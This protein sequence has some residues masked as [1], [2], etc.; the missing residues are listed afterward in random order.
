M[1]VHAPCR[2]AS[3]AWLQL[4][5]LQRGQNSQLLLQEWLVLLTSVTFEHV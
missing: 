4:V 2:G 3:A 1:A 5:K